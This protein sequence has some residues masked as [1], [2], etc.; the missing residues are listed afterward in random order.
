[1]ARVTGCALWA[2]AGN[3]CGTCWPLLSSE[4]A[5]RVHWDHF[6]ADRLQFGHSKADGAAES[7]NAAAAPTHFDCSNALH[8]AVSLTVRRQF[9]HFCCFR[10]ELYVTQTQ[11]VL[12]NIHSAASYLYTWFHALALNCT[13]SLIIHW[14]FYQNCLNVRLCT[15]NWNILFSGTKPLSMGYTWWKK[16]LLGM[17]KKTFFLKPTK[18]YSSCG[19]VQHCSLPTV[20]Q[21]YMPLYARCPYLHSDELHWDEL[22]DSPSISVA[23][24][25][26]VVQRCRS[27]YL[28]RPVPPHPSSYS[29]LYPPTH[30]HPIHPAIP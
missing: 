17:A 4:K 8:W 12:H 23:I 25:R 16:W 10:Q 1:M 27:A 20:Q 15:N 24:E 2:A 21:S 22:C 28:V 11:I 19:G 7:D 5:A 18:M 14:M 13:I 9:S 3:E 29:A 26:N 30:T 6:L